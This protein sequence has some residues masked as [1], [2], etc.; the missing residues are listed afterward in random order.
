MR[1]VITAAALFASASVVAAPAPPAFVYCTAPSTSP[2]G[3]GLIVTGIFRSRSEVA[4]IQTAF[5][6]YLRSS[7][8][9]YGNGWMF[10]EQGATCLGFT[11]RR[12]AEIQR[13]LDIS[14]IPQPTQSIFN[15]TFQLG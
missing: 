12:K 2:R 11:E 1:M 3:A 13:N 10:P 5:T 4:F 9:P 6:N 14:H 8:A 7:Y 15:V